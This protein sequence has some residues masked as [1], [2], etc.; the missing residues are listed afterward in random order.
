MYICVCIYTH[1]PTPFFIFISL[2]V[3]HR[4]LNIVLGPFAFFP[5]IFFC[6]LYLFYWHIVDLQYCVSFRRTAKGSSFISVYIY[7][8]IYTY[9][10]TYIYTYGAFLNGKEST[11]N[12]GNLQ[13][14]WVRSL[15]WEDPLEEEMQPIPVFLPGKFHGQRNL[16]SYSP[17]GRK[18]LDETDQLSKQQTT[19]DAWKGRYPEVCPMWFLSSF[20]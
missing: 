12:L 14:K 9:T 4:L 3:Y 16:A 19:S 20:N 5:Q 18:E 6:L 8:Y 1:T 17:W 2:M 15:C 10:D 7:T 13:E 11:C